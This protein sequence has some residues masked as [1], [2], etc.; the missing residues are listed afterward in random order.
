MQAYSLL[1][2]KFLRCLNFEPH[3]FFYIIINLSNLSLTTGILTS[4]QKTTHVSIELIKTITESILNCFN[5]K[6]TIKKFS[7]ISKP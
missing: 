7:K 1:K 4:R 6:T 2:I 5:F 3:L